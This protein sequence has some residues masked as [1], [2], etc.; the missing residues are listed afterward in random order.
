MLQVE[1]IAC[2]DDYAEVQLR[3]MRRCGF[4]ALLRG[5][6]LAGEDVELQCGVVVRRGHGDPRHRV[7]AHVAALL[8]SRV[9]PATIVARAPWIIDEF[10]VLRPDIRVAAVGRQWNGG[11]PRAPLIIEVATPDRADRHARLDLYA[12]APV[13]EYW[14]IDLHAGQIEVWRDRDP[15]LGSWGAS[16]ICRRGERV[17]HRAWPA[18]TLAV[19][20]LV[21]ATPAA[22]PLRWPP[23]AAT[24]AA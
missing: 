21:P 10:S 14:Q 23:G 13:D 19:D 18:L 12:Q 7:A 11:W 9:G 20:E 3:P 5:G 6:V 8:R 15:R 22:E 2:G 17:A 24:P 16:T 4:E 1:D